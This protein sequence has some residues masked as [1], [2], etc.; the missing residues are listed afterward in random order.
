MI[1][2][3]TNLLVYAHRTGVN[4]HMSAQQAVT[5]AQQDPR[6]W[7]FS[8]SVITEFWSVVTHPKAVGGPAKPPVAAAFI[9]ALIQGG[10]RVF[11]PTSGFHTRLTQNAGLLSVAGGRIYDLQIALMSS[12]A[13][14]SE[15]WTHDQ[16]FVQL[17]GLKVFDP[18]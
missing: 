16:G 8:A 1:A 10:A 2:L 6:G 4:Q 13:G 12:E 11:E 7:G 15:I 17:P 9:A 5:K 14:A 18:L 3:D